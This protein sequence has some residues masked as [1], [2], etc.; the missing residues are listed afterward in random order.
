MQSVLIGEL[1][2][3]TLLK[4]RTVNVGSKQLAAMEGIQH[5]ISLETLN[6]SGML[7][8]MYDAPLYTYSSFVQTRNGFFGLDFGREASYA[9][10]H[11]GI[12]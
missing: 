8:H 6:V 12:R 10:V 2:H 3:S 9:Q 4:F 5:C 7:I 1:L 11:S